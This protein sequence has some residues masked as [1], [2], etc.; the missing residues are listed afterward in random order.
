[1]DYGHLRNVGDTILYDFA[2][3]KKDGTGLVSFVS[4]AVALFEDSAPTI[5]ISGGVTLTTDYNSNTGSNHVSIVATTANGYLYDTGYTLKVTG[6]TVDS[7]SVV[8]VPLFKFRTFSANGDGI[9]S[10]GLLQA[11]GSTTVF[12]LP[13][14]QRSGVQV[15]DFLK[16]V[17]IP[18]R[19]IDTYNSGTGTG[20]VATAYISDPSGL[21]Y[22]VFGT[23]PADANFPIPATLSASERNAIADALL[24]R[25]D[26]I[27]SGITPRG[28]L[29][30][31]TADAAGQ[32]T[33]ADTATPSILNPS[34]SKTRIL[35]AGVDSVGNRAQPTLDLS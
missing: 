31:L 23:A 11:S 17:G 33:G 22:T 14:G 6:G 35:G 1:M 27:E 32:I 29:R 25:V 4:G 3:W 15:G 21:A 20:S 24:D 28:S 18:G 19:F 10:R 26:A 30:L 12:C 16:P 13:S 2:T 34:G 9:V 8:G 5:A 7:V